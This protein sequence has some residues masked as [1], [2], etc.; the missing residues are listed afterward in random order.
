VMGAP[1]SAGKLRPERPAAAVMFGG[2]F[3]A[4]VRT[5]IAYLAFV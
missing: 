1:V 2:S 4:T 3:G 5:L